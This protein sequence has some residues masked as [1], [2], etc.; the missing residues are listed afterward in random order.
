MSRHDALL[1]AIFPSSHAPSLVRLPACGTLLVAFFSGEREGASRCAIVV[2][3]ARD[4][5]T[6]SGAVEWSKPVVAAVDDGRSAQN[7][8]L[9]TRA[10][11]PTR[12]WLLHTSQDAGPLGV[13][14]RTSEVRL[15]HSDD[16]GDTWSTPRV[17][18]ARGRGAFIR[19]PLLPAL[20][21]GVLLL[22]MYV[23]PRGEFEHEGQHALVARSCDGGRT[24]T[25]EAK[26]GGTDGARGVQP[27][28]VRRPCDGA[29][30]A[31]MRNRTRNGAVL[32]SVSRD[33]GRTWTAAAATPLP[34]NNSSVA[35][36]ALPDG[37]CVVAFN[38]TATGA[39]WPLTLA[40][41]SDWGET[42][43]RVRDLVD[44]TGYEHVR[45]GLY[46][47]HSYPTLLMHPNGTQIDVAWT[48]CRSTVKH[49]R[50][51]IAWLA[52][53]DGLSVGDFRHRAGGAG[54]GG[55]GGGRS[56]D[57]GGGGGG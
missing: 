10:D 42:F 37:R 54:G 40:V 56:G 44:T 38:N 39:R 5:A 19:A 45:H 51:D 9:F 27:A 3:R 52:G 55:G 4:A 35:A 7:P 22:P 2:A 16:R 1:D 57:G 36:L 20:D 43:D 28:V 48:H 15:L 23:T 53:G 8:V 31:F 18:F 46:G 24:W 32:R 26:I 25:D 33:D 12:V 34:S 14:Q 11:E 41:S 47:E 6:G 21:A 49:A 13:S 30:V 29:L 17:V 50:I